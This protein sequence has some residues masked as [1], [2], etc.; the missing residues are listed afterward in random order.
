[1]FCPR[2]YL[3]QPDLKAIAVAAFQSECTVVPG[4]NGDTVKLQQDRVDTLRAMVKADPF[5]GHGCPMVTRVT[6]TGERLPALPLEY[7]QWR[8]I[9]GLQVFK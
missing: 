8:E 5:S 9:R 7:N 2:V 4:D 6:G 1:M 3:K